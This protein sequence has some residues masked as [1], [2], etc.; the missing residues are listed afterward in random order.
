M[1]DHIAD[2]AREF[3]VL[4]TEASPF[5]WAFTYIAELAERTA[6][7]DP[8]IAYRD[9]SAEEGDS[10]PPREMGTWHSYK[11]LANE[12]DEVAAQLEKFNDFL[13]VIWYPNSPSVWSPASLRHAAAELRMRS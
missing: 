5:H 9:S 1:S 8:P 3:A 4:Y 13:C 7:V 6:I 11:D 2:G 10:V 12:M